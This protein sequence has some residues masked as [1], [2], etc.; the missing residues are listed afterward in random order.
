MFVFRVYCL[1]CWREREELVEMGWKS[2]C[3]LNCSRSYHPHVRT[4]A[5]WLKA[6]WVMEAP[7]TGDAGCGPQLLPR[8]SQ[9]T[10]SLSARTIFSAGGPSV[11]LEVVWGVLEHPVALCA[12]SYQLLTCT[13]SF[14]GFSC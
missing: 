3:K 2:S 10:V 12:G 6:G 4:A 9:S 13:S 14:P 8:P 5:A 11:A 1:K 7:G